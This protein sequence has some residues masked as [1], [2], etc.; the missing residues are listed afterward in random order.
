M[1]V[2]IP[3]QN[4]AIT[5]LCATLLSWHFWASSLTLV[6]V[7]YQKHL[8]PDPLAKVVGRLYFYPTWPFTYL[9]R[10]HDYWTLVDSHVLLGAAPLRFLG[11]VDAL[12]ARGVRAVVNLCDEYEGPMDQYKKL[13]VVQLRLP[14]I[15]HTEPTVDDLAAAVAFIQ[16]KVDAGVRVYVHCKGGNGRSAAV[17]FAWLLHAHKFTLDEAQAY[18]NE[19]RS[20]RKKLFTQPN[21]MAYYAKLLAA[22]AASTGTGTTT[23]S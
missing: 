19:K 21:L 11:H 5:S 17:V 12:F 2:V 1:R 16:D 3:D 13:H 22:R 7:A 6:Y 8:L 18:M 15:D 10:R 23:Y 9:S 4:A 14:T 20:V